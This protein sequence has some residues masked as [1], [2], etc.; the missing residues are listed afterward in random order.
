MRY[1][2]HGQ[3][4]GRVRQ[5]TC[6]PENGFLIGDPAQVPQRRAARSYRARPAHSPRPMIP[7]KLTRFNFVRLH[8][9]WR[10]GKFLLTTSSDGPNS[11]PDGKLTNSRDSGL[12]MGLAQPLRAAATNRGQS[13]Y[14]CQPGPCSVELPWSTNGQRSL[15]QSA[16]SPSSVRI[17]QASA[18]LAPDLGEG[19]RFNGV[20]HWV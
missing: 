15:H 5:F 19:L 2:R 9:H 13:T 16:A 11:P 18:A 4:Q 10:A 14:G 1:P 12:A 3:N 7:G 8:R 6:P 17:E 20:R